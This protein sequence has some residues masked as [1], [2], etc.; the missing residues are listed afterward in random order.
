MF[1]SLLVSREQT[2][3]LTRF[4]THIQSVLSETIRIGTLAKGVSSALWRNKKPAT[5]CIQ[6]HIDPKNGLNLV[7]THQRLSWFSINQGMLEELEE[8]RIT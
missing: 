1:S 6:H 7:W 3:E 8:Y 5:Y 2:L 4:G